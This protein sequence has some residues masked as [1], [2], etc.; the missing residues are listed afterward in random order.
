[1]PMTSERTRLTTATV[2]PKSSVLRI[3]AVSCQ[4]TSWPREFVPIQYVQE[5]GTS[6]GTT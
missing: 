3:A 4:N 6:G 1:M 5:G 2:M